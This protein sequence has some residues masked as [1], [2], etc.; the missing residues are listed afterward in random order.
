MN[1]EIAILLAAG[2]GS[3]M[4]PLTRTVP[5]PLMEIQGIPLFETII[6]GLENRQVKRIYIVT[7][8]LG[9]QFQYLTK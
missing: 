3:R 6:K 5:K 9:E 8:Y 2:V 7:G 4:F 1:D